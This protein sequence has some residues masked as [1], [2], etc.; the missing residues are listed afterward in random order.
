MSKARLNK[1]MAACDLIKTQ[2]E[3]QAELISL[4]AL[5][6][7]TGYELGRQNAATG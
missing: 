3:K 4:V 7:Q 5:G 1:L 6:M 2:D